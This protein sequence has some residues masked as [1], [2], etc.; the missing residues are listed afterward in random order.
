MTDEVETAVA[1]ARAASVATVDT[2]G[3]L[4]QI[5]SDLLA[6]Q[7]ESRLAELSKGSDYLERIQLFTAGTDA[8]KKNNV[9]MNHYGIVIGKESI[10]DLGT[11]VPVLIVAFRAKALDSSGDE[12]SACYD[13]NAAEFERIKEESDIKD[14]GC[15][16]GPEY[17]VYLPEQNQFVTFFMGSKSARR[18][19]K[20]VNACLRKGGLLTSYLAS[21]KK[22]SWQTPTC[23]PNPAGITRMP[24]GEVLR[25]EVNKFLNPPKSTVE[26]ASADETAATSRE[27]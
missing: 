20:A 9:P 27:R 2:T 24:D 1:E 25:K 14:S 19:S 21:N 26:R 16:W 4:V 23:K 11:E 3:D 7:E 8:V 17:L 15:M 18:D 22:H 5:D 6:T 10:R 13:E 12:L